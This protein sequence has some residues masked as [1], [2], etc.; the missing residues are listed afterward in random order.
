MAAIFDSTI[1]L[2]TRMRAMD[3]GAIVAAA[4]A[5][6]TTC[7]AGGKLLVFGNGGSAADAQH[8][9]AELVGRFARER[10]A[11][12]ALALTTDTSVLTSLANDYAFD[13]VF[14]RQIEALGRA[15]DVAC[16]ISTSGR[17]PNVLKGLEAARARGLRTLALTGGDG[18]PI[19]AAADIHVNVP[20]ESTARV[21][22]VHRTVIH[23]ICELVER[24]LS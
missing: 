8:M 17:S 19:G 1:A 22:E 16:G 15:G 9:A 13:R 14:A 21:Q 5:I 23:A 7:Q 3:A 11:L 2:H 10:R 6:G 12:A 24:G 18:G 4:D 20:E